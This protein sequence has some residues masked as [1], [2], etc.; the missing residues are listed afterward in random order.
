MSLIR[1]QSMVGLTL[2]MIVFVAFWFSLGA[3]RGKLEQL[4]NSN[5][6]LTIEVKKAIQF[7]DNFE[8][9]KIEIED[10]EN[11]IAELTQLF[12]L[13]N[14]RT[15]V[16]YIVQKLASI[17]GLGLFQDQRN[18]DKPFRNEYYLEYSSSFKYLGGFH[19]FGHFLSLVSGYEKIINISDIVM[20]RNITKNAHPASIE[21]RLS[22]YVYDPSTDI[23]A[24]KFNGNEEKP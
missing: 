21:F 1:K 5:D 7:K 18:T 12:A 11:R 8:K 20:T 15:R 22:V 16:I 2:G 10:Q 4:K 23:S 9:L 3:K 14:E 6:K 17:S 19:E 24:A 13:A